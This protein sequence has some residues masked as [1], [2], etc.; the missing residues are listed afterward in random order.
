MI[1]LVLAAFA[2][3]AWGLGAEDLWWDESLTLQRAESALLPLLRNEIVLADGLS[4]VVSIDQHPFFYFLVQGFLLR[5]AGDDE[6]MLRFVSAAAATTLMVPV[7]YAFAALYV[8]RGVFPRMAP[9]W[10][11]LMATVSPFLLWFG[12]EARPYALWALL[13]MLSTY[14]LLRAG[15]PDHVEDAQAAAVRWPWIAGYVAT[16]LMFLQRTITPSSCCRSMPC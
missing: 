7:A 16:V 10:A 3:V 13:A 2:R 1:L 5:L 9:F 15:E 8:R 6:Y 11:A 12:Q 4:Q 14:A